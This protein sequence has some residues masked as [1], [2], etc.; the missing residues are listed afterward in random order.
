[1]SVTAEPKSDASAES[2]AR[3]LSLLERTIAVFTRPGHAWGG[4]RAR[5]QWWFP[6]LV[7]V[8][9]MGVTSAFIYERS[10]LPMMTEQFEKQ[11]ANGELSPEQL[12]KVQDTFGGTTG[13]ITNLVGQVIFLPILTL[14]SALGIW[15]AAGF[16]L[17]TKISYR[18]S[19]E[20]AAWSFLV[21]L[22]GFLLTSAIAWVRDMPI[23]DVHLGLAA[24]LPESDAPSPLMT[25]LTQAL[26]WLGPF[27]LWYVVVAILGTAALSG[28]PRRSV[29][30][31]LSGLYL[32]MV[33]FFST[34]S[35]RF[36]P[37]S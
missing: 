3:P 20:V 13:K 8:V 33:L 28:A 34:L 31:V 23:R 17:G 35:A 27:S 32:V 25:G 18:Q 11:A 4:L 5:A 22:P 9:V 19:L 14:L 24:L 1:M 10:I 21:T 12:E 6:M 15:I 16:M 37:G 26:D 2:D 7:T 36:S 30:W 29:A